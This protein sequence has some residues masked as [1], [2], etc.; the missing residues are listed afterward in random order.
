MSVKSLLR[1]V[2]RLAA[3]AGLRR[4]AG[5]GALLPPEVTEP[6]MVEWREE[7]AVPPGLEA[8][9]A[10]ATDA[11]KRELQE[12]L[13]HAV[14]LLPGAGKR[15]CRF[16]FADPPEPGPCCPACGA[17]VPTGEPPPVRSFCIMVPAPDGLLDALRLDPQLEARYGELTAGLLGRA[18]TE[19]SAR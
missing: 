11:E 15:G 18:S 14:E 13:N 12:L 16:R 10:V 3:N 5:C 4:C 19:A 1:Q 6:P 9:L 2:R 7:Y 8:L 17:P